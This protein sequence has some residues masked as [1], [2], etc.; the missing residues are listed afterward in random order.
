[1]DIEQLI[2]RAVTDEEFASELGRQAAA[3]A[4]AGIYSDEWKDY[5]SR[6]ADTPEELEE[7]IPPEN[8]ARIRWT[9]ITTLTTVT[10]AGCAT[11]TTTTT[12]TEVPKLCNPKKIGVEV[13]GEVVFPLAGFPIEG[14]KD[15]RGRQG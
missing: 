12:T 13:A 7:L 2:N 15:F 6:F 8:A 4:A 5:V 11:T 14:H 1:M 9:T 3:T 10:T